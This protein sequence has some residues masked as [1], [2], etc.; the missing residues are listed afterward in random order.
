VP[1]GWPAKADFLLK[2]VAET[3]GRLS[4][5]PGPPGLTSGAQRQPCEID[6][7]VPYRQAASRGA[8]LGSSRRTQHGRKRR[9]RT[10]PWNACT[11]SPMPSR[12]TT[13]RRASSIPSPEDGEFRQRPRAG[14]LGPELQGQGRD[15]RLLRAAV[16]Q[17]RRRPRGGHTKEFIC[18]NRAVTEVAPH[19][20]RSR[21]A[22][23]Q[24]WAGLRPLHLPPTV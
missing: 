24:E 21:P 12:A 23:R 3:W 15:P 19:R 9:T 13:A 6:D 8:D 22:E 7:G 20:G 18:G 1:H 5:I 14:L 2:I 17:H 4:E 16:C 11:R 10:S